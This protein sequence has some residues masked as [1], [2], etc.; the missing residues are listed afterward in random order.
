MKIDIYGRANCGFCER[1]KTLLTNRRLPFNYYQL[2]E[3]FNR[4]FIRKNFPTMFTFPVIL[5][6]GR[7]VGGYTDLVEEA[8]EPNF[9]K[10][11]LQE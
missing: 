9:G 10:S 4:E 2:D 3:H 5:I 11:L 1:A 6:D 8:A 7:L